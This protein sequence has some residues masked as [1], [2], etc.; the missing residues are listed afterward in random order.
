M[1]VDASMSAS[2]TEAASDDGVRGAGELD[3]DVLGVTTSRLVCVTVVVCKSAA[4]PTPTGLVR[5]LL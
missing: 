2:R 3:A 4:A 5:V 1:M